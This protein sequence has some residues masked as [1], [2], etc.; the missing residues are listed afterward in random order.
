MRIMAKKT[1]REAK[2]KIEAKS[3]I[4]DFGKVKKQ[5][6]KIDEKWYNYI[7]SEDAVKKVDD[8]FKIG[9]EVI[10]GYENHPWETND[11]EAKNDYRVKTII[12]VGVAEDMADTAEDD[13][14]P[15]SPPRGAKPDNETIN[16]RLALLQVAAA[17]VPCLEL[18]GDKNA[19][20]ITAVTTSIAEKLEF[21]VMG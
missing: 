13:G 20:S 16:K 11:G 7:G 9:E 4:F 19:N 12:P 15:F 14:H 18:K 6:Y 10:I 17:L 1:I 3:K 21:W 5:G 2:G 8:M